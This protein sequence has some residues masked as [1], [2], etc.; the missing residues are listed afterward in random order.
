LGVQEGE[1]EKGGMKKHRQ[2]VLS[3]GATVFTF[4]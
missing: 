4:D 1:E 3:P 2:A